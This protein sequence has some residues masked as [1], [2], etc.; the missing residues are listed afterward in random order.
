MS[1]AWAAARG[2][3]EGSGRGRGRPAAMRAQMRRASKWSDPA[4][5][6][7]TAVHVL[8]LAS[9]QQADPAAAVAPG[10]GKKQT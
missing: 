2:G 3:A 9:S 6:V 10:R 5:A 8:F 7:Q 1:E 4:R